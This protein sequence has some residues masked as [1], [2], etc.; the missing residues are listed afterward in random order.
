MVLARYPRSDEPARAL[1]A[2]LDLAEREPDP[3]PGAVE[4]L[5]GGW[6]ADEALAIAVYA[7]VTASSFEA[8]VR[9]A[10]NH[11]GDSDSTG[12]MAG[13]LLGAQ[14]GRCAVPEGWRLALAE[15]ELVEEVARDFAVQV[16]G[17]GAPQVDAVLD[18]A[19]DER[20]GGKPVIDLSR[21][22]GT[23]R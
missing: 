16:L 19:T 14:L 1:L 15:H 3:H 10:V 9:T 20:G 11:S 13:N 8:G 6:V 2:A 18:L 17:L 7:A 5:G 12:A 22:D 23:A 21:S 4:Q